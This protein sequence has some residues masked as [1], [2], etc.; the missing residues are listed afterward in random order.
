VGAYVEDDDSGGGVVRWDRGPRYVGFDEC[1]EG[2]WVDRS[3][4]VEEGT[5]GAGETRRTEEGRDYLG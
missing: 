4:M 1:A 2:M 3:S 5:E